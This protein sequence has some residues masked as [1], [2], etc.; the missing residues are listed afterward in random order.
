MGLGQL[1]PVAGAAGLKARVSDRK[2]PGK[3]ADYR[4]FRPI[5][6]RWRDNDACGHVNNAVYFSYLDTAVTSYL[7]E[8]G[9]LEP[10][11]SRI[12]G[13]VVETGCR[14]FAPVAFPD[15]VTAAVRVGR[16]G[17]SSV[18]YEVGLFR[19]EEDVASA[20]GHFVHVYVER[21]TRRPIPLPETLIRALEPLL[22]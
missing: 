6:T 2:P 9:F 3:R 7:I 4:V 17:N 11:R 1:G 21:E 5:T 8:S 10:G 13:L 20:E 15:L 19:N 12:V 22:V 16:Q 14:Y 18:R